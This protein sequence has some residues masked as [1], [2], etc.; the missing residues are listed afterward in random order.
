MEKTGFEQIADARQN[1][2]EIERLRHKIASTM[3]ECTVPDFRS[4]FP[5]DDQNGEVAR[6]SNTIRQPIHDAEP[7]HARHV[8]VEQDQI[9]VAGVV[10]RRHRLRVRG[11]RQ[12]GIT[13]VPQ[14]TLEHTEVRSLVIY[15]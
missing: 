1:F 10:Q 5:G 13:S 6:C 12:V 7:V 15:Q 11:A 8:E 4:S 9:G 3:R 14:R 2:G